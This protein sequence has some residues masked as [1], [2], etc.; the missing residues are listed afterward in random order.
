MTQSTYVIIIFSYFSFQKYC[1]KE[2]GYFQECI[3][4]TPEL[5]IN[6]YPRIVSHRQESPQPKDGDWRADGQRDKGQGINKAVTRSHFL[7]ISI[8]I[9][10]YI[11]HLL[12]WKNMCIR[13]DGLINKLKNK[14]KKIKKKAI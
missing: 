1:R 2:K 10:Y 12:I 11:S 6:L 14:F 9:I 7:Y 5:V 4:T 13:E 3:H 8:S